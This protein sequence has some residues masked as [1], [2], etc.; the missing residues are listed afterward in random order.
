MPL[1]TPS[2][3]QAGETKITSKRNITLMTLSGPTVRSRRTSRIS[4]SAHQ[5]AR[6]SQVTCPRPTEVPQT[7]ESTGEDKVLAGDP[8]RIIGTQITIVAN[9]E[10]IK[11][12]TNRGDL[13]R[14]IDQIAIDNI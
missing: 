13:D 2:Q 12:G 5:V 3:V 11:L 1:L 4:K 8:I 10:T 14:I 9:T 6:I 7:A